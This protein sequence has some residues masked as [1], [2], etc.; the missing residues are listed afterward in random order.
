MITPS[1]VKRSLLRVAS[2]IDSAKHPSIAKTIQE[3][4]RITLALD[5]EIEFAPAAS[6]PEGDLAVPTSQIVA[7]LNHWLRAKY[8]IDAAYRSFADRIKGPWRDALVEHWQEHAKEERG[9]AYDLAMKIVGL[10]SDPIQ[11]AINVPTCPANLVAFGAVLIDLELKAIDAAHKTIEMSGTM[12]ALAVMAENM[13]LTD[14]QHLDDLR[15]MISNLNQ[16][17]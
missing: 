13:M 3:L 16:A 15:R 5:G 11:T 1:T 12:R 14:T 7:H 8:E 9:H 6:S 17:L 2:A 4:G 10:G